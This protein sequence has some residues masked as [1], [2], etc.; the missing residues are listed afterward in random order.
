[1][2]A[3]SIHRDKDAACNN[4][5]YGQECMRL[6]QSYDSAVLSYEMLL[7]EAPVS[8]RTMLPDPLSL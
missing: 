2:D 3:R 5:P 7:N 4:D 6:T 8:C 1:M